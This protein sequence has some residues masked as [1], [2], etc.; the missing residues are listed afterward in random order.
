MSVNKFNYREARD[1]VN[2]IYALEDILNNIDRDAEAKKSNI[3]I[4]IEATDGKNGWPS[5]YRIPIEQNYRIYECL[6][7][8]YQNIVDDK[9]KEL[10]GL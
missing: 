10:N 8:L 2:N 5:T 3:I 4:N 1:I 7:E 6:H 9:Y